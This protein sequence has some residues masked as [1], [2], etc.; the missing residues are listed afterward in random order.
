MPVLRNLYE[1]VKTELP[2]KGMKRKKAEAR[3]EGRALREEPPRLPALVKNALDQF[4]AHYAEY[5]RGR[6]DRREAK[7]DLF[8]EPP[9]FIV[10]CSNTS[11][12]K[13]V[14]KY[15]AGYEEESG[16]GGEAKVVT[17]HF[18]LFSNYDHATLRPRK[19]PPTILIDSEALE[20][21][22]INDEF[23]NIFAPEIDEFKRDYARI[24]GQG[25]AERIADAEILR[26]V[27]NT[28]GKPGKLGSHVRCVV[29]VSMLTEGWDANTVTHIMGLRAFGSQLLCEQV[30]GRALRRKSYFLQGYDK[31]GNP[32]D[33][34]RRIVSE[35]FPPEY[36]HIIGIPFRL[37]KGGETIIADPPD[38]THVRALPERQK[39]REIVFPNVTGYRLENT[40][41][42]ILF[43]FSGIE[44]YEIDGSRTPIKTI[45]GTPVSADEQELAVT[46]VLEKRDQEIIYL[47]TKELVKY[48]FSDDDGNPGFHLFGRLKNIVEVWYRDKVRLVNIDGDEYKRLLFFEDPKK[49][50]DHIARGINPH[51]NTAEYVRPVLNHYNPWSGT[52]YVTGNTSKDVFP[53]V[54]SHVNFVA[55]DSDWEGK[56]AKALEELHQVE[57]YVKNQFLGFTVPYVKDGRDRL[58]FPDFIARCRRPDGIV[59]NLIIE[60]SGMSRDKAEKTWFVENRWLPAVNAMAARSGS[61]EWRFIEVANDIRDIKSRIVNV[62][63]TERN[64]PK[65]GREGKPSTSG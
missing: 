31:A 2:R 15:I 14:Y 55:L 51:I 53:T 43:D 25:A 39:E 30:A 47:L 49:V 36:A 19:K 34:G 59:F 17:G 65:G 58:Y 11:V 27:V 54:K 23:K 57:S 20:S 61:G 50:V 64:G 18:D 33:D 1:H 24:H 46:S 8:T 3:K 45:L 29:S 26:E 16:D 12:S 21:G 22:R 41:G 6:R 13:E 60:I 48:H 37:F 7:G 63:G 38:Y 44:N 28:V 52:K 62:C 32:T 9:V 10:V 40:G 5:Y 56:A 35:K 4:T 42:E